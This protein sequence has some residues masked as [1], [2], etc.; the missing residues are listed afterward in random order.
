MKKITV[1]FAA[2]IFLTACNSSNESNTT[3]LKS[4]DVSEILF[5]ASHGVTAGEADWVI[6]GGFSTFNDDIN[7]LGFTT[8]STDY[9]TEITLKLL[10]RYKAFI[11]PE[12][13]IP[14]KAS[15]QQ[16]IKEYVNSGGSIMMIADHYN[17]DR[18]LN[19]FDASEIFNGYR[20]GAFH[21][22][23][24]GMS[25]DEINADRMQDVIS[26][27]FLSE[28]F[29]V[30]F[31]YNALDD[32]VLSAKD[33]DNAFGLLDDVEKVNMHAGSTIMIT[34]PE[35]AKGIIYPEK[36]SKHDKWS[37]A[38]DQ[39]VYTN[40]FKDEGA[41]IA[42]SK[43]GKGKAVFIGDSSIVEDST[44]K[45]VR[46]DNGQEKQTYDGIRE[47]DHQV[48]ME[49]LIQWMMKQED[50]SSLKGKVSLDK[51]T[52][53][54]KFEIPEQSTE[55]KR[56]PWGTPGHDYKWYDPSTFEPG[57]FGKDTKH[58]AVS[59]SEH[60]QNNKSTNKKDNTDNKTT[61]DKTITGNKIDVQYPKTVSIGQRFTVDVYT[62]EQLNQVSIELIDADGEQVGLFDGN[63]PGQSRAY[64]TKKNENRFHSYFHGKI[65]REANGEITINIY[66]KNKLIQKEKMIVR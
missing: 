6:D 30:R 46:E 39:G 35:I 47:M 1:L 44:P 42:I 21:N 45:Y 51:P 31:R 29:G 3:N 38:V 54:L 55:P 50:Y 41:F 9:Q 10:K 11:M 57:S 49:N 48:L 66:A 53:V 40:G 65:A 56:E 33:E 16:A 17:A 5:D 20:R 34:N 15:E 14:L 60:Q 22:I 2:T 24:K 4:N 61:Q 62:Q 59:S 23:T 36:L 43:L 27:D 63:P 32:V 7:K 64:D 58:I 26:S 52:K 19:R 37:H 8:A 13:N 25:Q 12:P 18:N 28:T